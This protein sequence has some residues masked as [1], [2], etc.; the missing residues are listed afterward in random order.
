MSTDITNDLADP[1]RVESDQSS[2]AEGV[3]PSEQG[4]DAGQ[5]R[6]GHEAPATLPGAQHARE[7]RAAAREVFGHDELRP[8]QQEATSAVLDGHDVLLVL[9]TGAGS[10]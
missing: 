5:G 1:A 8:G 4:T 7:I 9:P 6:E 10:W 2:D 3:Q